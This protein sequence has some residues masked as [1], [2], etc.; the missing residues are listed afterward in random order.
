MKAAVLSAPGVLQYTDLP[1]PTPFGDR[2]VLVRVGAVGVC[3]SDLLR[4]AHGTAYHYPLVL[5]HEFSGVV[6]RPRRTA[7][8]PPVT[9]WRCSRCCRGTTTR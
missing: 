1:E 3:G 2:P 7:G 8:S 4:F 6:E 9:G 5:G